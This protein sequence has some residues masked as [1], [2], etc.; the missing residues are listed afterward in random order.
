LTKSRK[1]RGSGTTYM[2]CGPAWAGAAAV[3]SCRRQGVGFRGL[4]A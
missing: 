2:R 4:T 3:A 1:L